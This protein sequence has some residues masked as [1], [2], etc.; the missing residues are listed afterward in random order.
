MGALVRNDWTEGDMHNVTTSRRSR[1]PFITKCA[2][3]MQ[4]LWKIATR[5]SAASDLPEILAGIALTLSPFENR[6]VLFA[7]ISK[8]PTGDPIQSASRK[9]HV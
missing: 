2:G 3:A 9:H 6:G 7:F 1:A 4:K 8:R 5:G